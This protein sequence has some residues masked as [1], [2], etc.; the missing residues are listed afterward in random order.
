MGGIYRGTRNGDPPTLDPYGNL[1]FETK[2]HGAYVHSRLYKIA[3]R[4]DVNPNAVPPEPD[5]AEGAETE[6]GQTWV[7]RLKQGV[8]FHNV[9][10]VNGRELTTEDVLFSWDRLVAPESPGATLV[11]HVTGVEAVDSYTL[12][13]ELDA[14]SASFLDLLSD[15]NVLL[16]MPTESDGGYDP[17]QRMIGTGPW[18]LEEYEPSVRFRYSRHPEFYMEGQPYLDG[19][20]LAIVPE[21]ANRLAQFQA[22]NTHGFGVSGDDV[23]TLRD[24][25]E[26]AQ[27]FS[28]QPIGQSQVF[29]SPA[30][31]DPDAPWRDDRFRRAISM[32]LDRDALTDVAYNSNALRDA[33]FDVA[34]TWNNIV[35]AGFG[36]RWWLD[37]QSEAHGPTGAN[38]SYNPDE[39]RA[40]LDAVGAGG[41]TFKYQY[42][43]RYGAG[44]MKM[45]EATGNFM[46]EIGLNP[47]TEVQDYS[48]VFITQ[49]F[50]GNFH[51]VAFNP[52]TPF[53][54]VGAFFSR[55]F[56]EDPANSGRISDPEISD[57]DMKQSRELDEDTRRQYI[58]D[59]QR[60]NAEMMWYVPNQYGA[61]TSFTA[62]QPEVR[63]IV[64]TRGYGGATESLVHTWLDV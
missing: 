30:D 44:W 5:V 39:A 45:A 33:G 24:Q 2:S 3:A 64:Q 17:L 20:D 8:K 23:L 22:H 12:R 14:P 35:P 59:I 52:Q 63:G 4:P 32:G 16:I 57:L 53:P 50:R 58:H 48:A 10:P 13:F 60:R 55:Y 38:F 18:I 46:S 28:L 1:S 54:E 15:T 31:M 7:V 11:P 36:D 40:L 21:Y 42:T 37:P 49:T 41:L 25:H 26:G 9:D 43:D 19:V 29:F 62:Y 6:D 47:E 56:G 34:G 27:W 61:G 51:G